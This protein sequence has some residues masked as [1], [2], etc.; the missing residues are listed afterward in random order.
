MDQVT[1][2]FAAASG[3]L[4]LARTPHSGGADIRMDDDAPC[5]WAAAG[6]HREVVCYLHEKGVDIRI[7]DD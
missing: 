3:R 4:E 6:G 2:A 7:R 5:R 1:L